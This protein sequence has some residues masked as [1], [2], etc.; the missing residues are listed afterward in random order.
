MTKEE[1]TGR[2]HLSKKCV[3]VKKSFLELRPKVVEPRRLLLCK[4]GIPVTMHSA[5]SNEDDFVHGPL[6]RLHAA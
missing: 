3:R 2:H 1:E 5:N 6:S 4:K